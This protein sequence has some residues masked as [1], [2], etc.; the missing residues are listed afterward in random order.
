MTRPLEGIRVLELARIL[1]GPWAGQALADLGADV[2]KVEQPGQG[3]DTR[4]WGPPFVEAV[5]G[6]HLDAAYFHACNRGKRSVAV[7]FRDESGQRLVREL[8]K[9]SDILIEN[10]KVGGLKKYGLDYDSLKEIN[11][12]LIYCSI[13]GFGQTGP[14]AARAG[15]DFMIQGMGG[16]MDL[17]G[18]PEGEPQKVGVAYADIFTGLYSV[19]GIQSALIEREKTGEGCHLDMA[20]LDCQ[21]G[22]LANQALNYLVSGQAPRR[23]GNAHPNIVPYQVFPVLDGHLI[24]AVGNNGQFEKLCQ[25]LDCPALSSDPR[26]AT[27]QARI[28]AREEL[29][30]LLTEKTSLWKRDDLLETLAERGVPVGPINTV[31]D[32]FSDRH[33]QSRRMQV[34]LEHDHASDGTIPSVRLPIIRNG[35]TLC[36]DR[37]APGLGEHTDQ[38]LAEIGWKE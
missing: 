1:A 10:F 15:Y 21:T 37:H 13:T 25:V 31:A 19:I 7:D 35:E 36:S 23:M 33:V 3:D 34:S 16:I 4:G 32:V 11:P 14:Y 30:A 17:T 9:R 8:V 20:L 22:V 18:D 27:N 38:I 29:I 2:I 24:I 28:A 5:D 6:D 26:F 12:R